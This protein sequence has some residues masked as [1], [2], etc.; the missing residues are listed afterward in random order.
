MIHVARMG[1]TAYRER[2]VCLCVFGQDILYIIL[3]TF[4]LLN[5]KYRTQS[6][7]LKLLKLKVN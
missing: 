3:V 2:S 1:E 7:S 6:E 4:A 5:R